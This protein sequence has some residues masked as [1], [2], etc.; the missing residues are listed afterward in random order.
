MTQ[1]Q[2]I[3]LTAFTLALM[4]ACGDSADN[5]NN[6]NVETRSLHETGCSATILC[7][8]AAVCYEADGKTACYNPCDTSCIDG[9]CV[10]GACLPDCRNGT[11]QNQLV[12]DDLDRCVPFVEEDS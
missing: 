4:A 11:C 12:C 6:N 5:N 3:L 7:E 1:L 9:T 2:R 10:E 8:Q